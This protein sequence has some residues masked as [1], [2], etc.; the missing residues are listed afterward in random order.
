MIKIIVSL[1]ITCVSLL[2]GL[3]TES[4]AQ[5]VETYITPTLRE[6]ESGVI[7]PYETFDLAVFRFRFSIEAVNNDTY[8]LF[9]GLNL[10]HTPDNYD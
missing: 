1:L 4:S 10:T 6:V 8:V 9:A 7:H 5:A 2:G 3:R